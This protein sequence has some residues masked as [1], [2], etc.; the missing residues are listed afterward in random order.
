MRSLARYAVSNVVTRAMLSEIL[1]KRDFEELAQADG[2]AEAWA[3]L[4]KTSY[5][6][7]LPHYAGEAAAEIERRFHQITGLRFRRAVRTLK[8]K[9][10]AVGALLLSRWDLD[11]LE[12]ALRLWHGRTP[13]GG[14]TPA[15]TTFV[16]IVPLADIMNA[17]DIG[18]VA[19]ALAHTPYAEPLALS[20]HAYHETNSIFRIETALERDYYRRL[21][22]SVDALGGCDGHGAER[23]IATEIDVLNLTGLARLLTYHN[24]PPDTLGN[25]LVPGRSALSRQLARPGLSAE[26]FADHFEGYLAGVTREPRKERSPL[27]GI[28]LLETLVYEEMAARARNA[29]AAYPFSISGVLAFYILK[30]TELR[31]LRSVF[32]AKASGL[33]AGATRAR[34]RGLK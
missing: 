21:L 24:V 1:S 15:Y 26:S 33:E 16:H 5:G 3:T 8:A 32:A 17:R 29:L 6:G 13:R 23:L 25:S 18:E 2:V 20:V 31:N 14:G 30:R 22:D 7:W 19:A 10:R 27:D 28:A 4:E 9:P 12:I 34:L 11:A